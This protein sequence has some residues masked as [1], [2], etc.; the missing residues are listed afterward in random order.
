MN[1][2]VFVHSDLLQGVVPRAG[3]QRRLIFEFLESLKRQ[4][5]Q[6]GD[7]VEKNATLRELQI[8]IMVLR[9]FQWE[10][11]ILSLPAVK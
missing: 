6:L 9:Y 2:E 8:K 3:L 10:A 11:G 7:F 1:Y 5:D 4:P